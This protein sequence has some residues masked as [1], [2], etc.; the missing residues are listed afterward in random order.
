MAIE[1]P[2]QQYRRLL[3][4][5]L[6][7]VVDTISSTDDSNIENLTLEVSGYSNRCLL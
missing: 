7:A 4:L 3:F 5:K 6:R 2:H 1:R